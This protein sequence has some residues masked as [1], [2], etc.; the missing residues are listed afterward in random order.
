MAARSPRPRPG[1]LLAAGPTPARC[2]PINPNIH[3]ALALT[4]RGHDSHYQGALNRM[5]TIANGLQL[6]I[7]FE[8]EGYAAHIHAVSII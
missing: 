4:L 7:S 8:T 3:P 2:R 1:T 6:T 5:V